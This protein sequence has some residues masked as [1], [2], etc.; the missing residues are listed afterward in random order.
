MINTEELQIGNTVKDKDGVF[1]TIDYLTS[2]EKGNHTLIQEIN[3]EHITFILTTEA[4]AIELKEEHLL[5]FGFKKKENTFSKGPF[6]VH[7]LGKVFYLK[8]WSYGTCKLSS[9]HKLQ[10]VYYALTENKLKWNK[11]KVEN[12]LSE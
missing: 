1:I 10:N 5:N 12:Q 4:Y 6:E 8:G 11:E 3:E 9:I 7:I 2:V